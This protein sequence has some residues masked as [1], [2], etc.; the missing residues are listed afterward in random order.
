LIST[1]LFV[2]PRYSQQFIEQEQ[3]LF[4][5][6]STYD[7]IRSIEQYLQFQHV[8]MPYRQHLSQSLHG[9]RTAPKQ[10]TSKGRLQT[11]HLKNVRIV[12]NKSYDKGEMNV[13]KLNI[14]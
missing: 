10:F 13:D 7:L 1:I 3:Q 5:V 6:Q 9:I 11:I 4:A 8:A 14:V 12:M 2:V